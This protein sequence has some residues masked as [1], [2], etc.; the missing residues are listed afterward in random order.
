MTKSKLAHKQKNI[1]W[2]KDN[3]IKSHCPAKGIVVWQRPQSCVSGEKAEQ[4]GITIF[5]EIEPFSWPTSPTETPNYNPSI[6]AQLL[7][8]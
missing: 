7:N 1:I 3:R 5:E 8:F 2:K 4:M 6:H